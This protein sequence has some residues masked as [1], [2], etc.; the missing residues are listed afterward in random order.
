MREMGTGLRRA[1]AA[2]AAVV[3][4]GCGPSPIAP[5]RIEAAIEPTF[6]N[7]AHVQFSW[8]GLP[9][10]A[11]SDF[12]VT[13]SCSRLLQGSNA[14]AGD[15]RCRLAWKGPDGQ[16]LHDA[17][18]LVVTSDGCYTAT[19]AEDNLGGPTLK[20]RDGRDVRNLLYA[21]EGCFDTA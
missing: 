8:L 15:W 17:Y 3:M 11:A 1:L 19:A 16:T 13:A 5:G 6:A 12:A 21:F 18:D 4:S 10:M 2:I 20:A 9:P 7:L 14:G